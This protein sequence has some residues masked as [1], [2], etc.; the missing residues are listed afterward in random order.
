LGRIQG[1]ACYYAAG[2]LAPGF[3]HSLFF[4]WALKEKPKQKMSSNKASIPYA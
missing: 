3:R 4:T 1:A 2:R